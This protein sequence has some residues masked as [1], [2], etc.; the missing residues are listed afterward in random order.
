M[1]KIL[2]SIIALSLC[3]TSCIQFDDAVS[4]NYGSGPSISVDIT[5]TRDNGFTFTLTPGEGT[6]F[7]SYVVASGSEA[8]E[9]DGYAL[10]QEQYGGIASGVL[11]ATE[12]PTFTSNLQEG[13]SPNTSY[14]VYA[15]A[16]SQQGIVGEVTSAVV[17]TSDGD[18]PSFT[19]MQAVEGESAV[20]VSFSENVMRGTGTVTARYFAEWSGDFVDIA[21]EDIQ[22]TLEGNVVTFT[23]NNVPAAAYAF[24]SWA[25]GA[26]VDSKG[27]LC[28]AM[29]SGLNSAGD[30]FTGVY[31][32]NAEEPFT[33]EE[34]LAGVTPEEGSAFSDWTTFMGEITFNMDVY[35][36]DN[37]LTG[38]EIE[39]IYT[40]AGKTT[41]IKLPSTA[42]ET[43]GKAFRFV[44]PESPQYGDNVSLKVSE[45]TFFDVYGNPN[46]EFTLENAWFYSYGY[47][48]DMIIGDYTLSYYLYSEYDQTGEMI[49]ATENLTIAADPDDE[50]GVLISGFS[51]TNTPVKW[52]FDGDFGTITLPEEQTLGIV[53]G[54][55]VS[56]CGNTTDGSLTMQVDANGNFGYNDI[57]LLYNAYTTDTQTYLGYLEGMIYPTFQK[58]NATSSMKM[59]TRTAKGASFKLNRSNA[60]FVR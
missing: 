27:N 42:W 19:A 31:F 37:T 34:S 5:E 1:K 30:D 28:P 21:A 13:I 58:A 17:L 12:A 23:L 2:Y 48:R 22:T 53:Y 24:V 36:N 10:L 46:A 29:T 6:V 16:A 39:V 25:E 57:G 52:I 43:D 9:L 51:G 8:E 15:V 7:Y 44:L 32:R 26:F 47:Q 60:K 20:A 49:L 11:N 38:D 56:I 54:Y 35:R 55:L 18:A 45:G 40:N 14:V 3:L 4:E 33:L 59:A 50:N 41:T